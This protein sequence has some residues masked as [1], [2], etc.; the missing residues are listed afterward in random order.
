MRITQQRIGR[1]FSRKIS[2]RIMTYRLSVSTLFGYKNSK[3][4][5]A[6][7]NNKVK[8]WSVSPRRILSRTMTGPLSGV[9]Y[10][11]SFTAVHTFY[12]QQEGLYP[13]QAFSLL[14]Q[15]SQFCTSVSL[16][17][18]LEGT[19]KL[20]HKL[21]CTFNKQKDRLN[22]LSISSGLVHFL[23]F[24]SFTLFSNVLLY[25]IF[26]PYHLK[27]LTKFEQRLTM[28]GSTLCIPSN[29]FC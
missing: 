10:Q 6:D 21:T 16:F 29:Y 2:S 11:V 15:F 12:K 26:I 13:L 9:W 1:N 17:I 24:F 25:D 28:A 19:H 20:T 5:R 27:R 4:H 23:S 14:E 18:A 7:K 3:V 22:S 8:N